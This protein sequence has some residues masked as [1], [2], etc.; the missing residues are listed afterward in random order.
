[1]RISNKKGALNYSVILWMFAL[2]LTGIFLFL[3]FSS[4]KNAT[5]SFEAS[6]PELSYKFPAAFVHSFL[7]Y[8]ILNEDAVSVGLNEDTRQYFVKDLFWLDSPES[9][10]IIEEYRKEYIGRI[11]E[12]TGSNNMH[13]NWG[14]FAGADYF[15]VENTL[16]KIE[17]DKEDIDISFRNELKN[18]NYLFY[19]TTQN[20]KFSTV[21]F[22]DKQYSWSGG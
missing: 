3:S 11:Q 16:L 4:V 20:G 17:Y 2:V 19:I 22:K 18:N 10:T 21:Y 12:V 15:N 6:A 13:L 7:N 9:R 5:A 1:M 8:P 14:D